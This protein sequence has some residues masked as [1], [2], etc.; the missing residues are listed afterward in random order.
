MPSTLWEDVMLGERLRV[1]GAGKEVAARD[2]VGQEVYNEGGLR[3]EGGA[4]KKF[5]SQHPAQEPRF[6]R[7]AVGREARGY[8]RCAYAA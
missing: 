4:R 3:G 7:S 5:L 8:S 6:R 2:D 1:G